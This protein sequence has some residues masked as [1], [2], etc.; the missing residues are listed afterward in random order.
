MLGSIFECCFKL[1]VLCGFCHF[2]S[3]FNW[4]GFDFFH[5]H[6]LYS[7]FKIIPKNLYCHDERKSFMSVQE[8]D[9]FEEILHLLIHLRTWFQI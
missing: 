8:A 7:S 5:L 1:F 4:S 3:L 9:V 2:N 6:R